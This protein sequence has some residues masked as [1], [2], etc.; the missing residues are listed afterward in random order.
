EARLIAA[1]ECDTDPSKDTY[2]FGNYCE[3]KDT[4]ILIDRLY[5][6]IMGSLSNKASK[7]LLDMLDKKLQENVKE[8][9]VIRKESEAAKKIAEQVAENLKNNTVDMM[10]GINPPTENVKDRK[11]L[12]Q[13]I[14]KGKPGILKLWKDGEWEPVVPDVESVK[15]ETVEQVNKDI[16]S[17]KSELNKKVEEAQK[18]TTGK[19]NE[20]KESLQGV[21]R[22]ISNVENE[23]GEMDKK[24]TKFEQDSSRFKQSIEE[25]TKKDSQIT[26]KVNH[27]ESNVDGTTKT[28]STMQETTNNLT[29][30]TTQMKEQAGKI[31]EKL[32]SVEKQANTLTN[33]TT[34]MEKSVDGIKE[35]VT[36]VENKQGGFDKRVATVEKTAD[37]I[38]QNVTSLQEIQTNQGKQLQEA[39]SGWA[40]TAKALEGKVNIKQV[41]DYVGGFQI[42]ELKNTVTKN[43]QELMEEIAKKVATQDYNKKVTE[44]ER[45]ITANVDGVSILSRKHETFVNETYQAYVTKTSAKLRVLD[46]GI[47]AQVKK[48]DMIAA[49]NMSAEKIT[50]DVSKLDI[51]ADTVVKWLTAKGID[52]D[53]MKISGDKV[54]IDKNGITAKMAD[55]F[56]EDARGQKFS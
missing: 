40:N 24:V 55:F 23:K 20:V 11:T 28:I 49:L 15:K 19:F 27:I 26:E 17:T 9:E 14:S 36:K 4:R 1:D 32:I 13:D 53:V 35:T 45:S 31:S 6:Q 7:E 46:T 56:F 33:Q 39:K 37:S 48:G 2:I 43:T 34:E 41:E 21:S 47:L 5:E 16:E 12:W 10:E 3:M 18:E 44:L 38:K 50:I 51:N 29:K 52:T 22:K 25:L 30:I 54:T 8:T 42:P